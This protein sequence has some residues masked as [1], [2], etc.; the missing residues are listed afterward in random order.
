METKNEIVRL[1]YASRACFPV[2]VDKS[3]LN[4]DVGRI[5]MQSRKNNPARG[6]VGALYFGDGCFFQC[7]EGPAAEVDALY[8]RLGQDERH[9]DL[10]VL[11]REAIA[12]TSFSTWSMKYVPNASVVRKLLDRHGVASFDPYRFP[13]ALVADMV[14]LLLVG[15]DTVLAA[16][17]K[18][19]PLSREDQ[20]L[21]TA[22]RA[23]WLAA[24]AFAMSL[25]ALAKL[26]L[27]P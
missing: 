23:Q 8:A 22:R 13:P 14:D 17:R 27:G 25:A 5:L 16:P 7:L 3:G 15:P 6:L 2:A 19:A 21:A 26:L 10:L 24:L 9:R 12:Q 18:P 11:S 1:V 20:A 4:A